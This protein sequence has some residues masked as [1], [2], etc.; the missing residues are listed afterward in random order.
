M[1]VS[2]KVSF[3]RKI[4]FCVFVYFGCCNYPFLPGAGHHSGSIEQ[5]LQQLDP[6][7]RLE[8]QNEL[9]GE[10]ALLTNDALS[11]KEKK[12]LE[13]Y[14]S[15]KQREFST[16]WYKAKRF[17]KNHKGKI[18]VGSVFALL[19][20]VSWLFRKKKT[21][22]QKTITSSPKPPLKPISSKKY[23]LSHGLGY[24]W[25]EKDNDEDIYV[26][27]TTIRCW[28][29]YQ[30][31]VNSVLKYRLNK[32]IDEKHTRGFY[33]FMSRNFASPSPFKYHSPCSFLWDEFI[34][35]AF[36]SDLLTSKNVSSVIKK[37]EESIYKIDKSLQKG[38]DYV[39]DGNA[40]FSNL[41]VILIGNTIFIAHKGSL[42][43]VLSDQGRAIS[44]CCKE[45]DGK[46]VEFKNSHISSFPLPD[47]NEF[48]VIGSYQLWESMKDQEVIDFVRKYVTD[49]NKAHLTNEEIA[50]KLTLH[51]R[52]KQKYKN[53]VDD[54]DVFIVFF[55][56]KIAE[57]DKNLKDSKNINNNDYMPQQD[58]LDFYSQESKTYQP[59]STFLLDRYPK[60]KLERIKKVL[61]AH[62]RKIKEKK[63]KVNE[64]EKVVESVEQQTSSSNEQEKEKDKQEHTRQK[65]VTD[66][67]QPPKSTFLLDRYPKEKLERIKKVLEAH[68]RKIKE[69]KEKVNEKEKVVESVEQQTS[70]SK[71]QKNRKQ[72]RLKMKVMM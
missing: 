48:I 59:R 71:E 35:N 24:S 41:S 18:T 50:Q 46:V 17:I 68:L 52:Q 70:S 21:V 26:H 65:K 62:L 44:L 56:R 20:F 25:Y 69:K 49:K 30:N 2:Q 55:N 27:G 28:Y 8:I 5:K 43:A 32:K 33:Q 67:N 7:L 60:E 4:V 54:I 16:R 6:E 53:D 15:A 22:P 11:E 63:E 29:G 13:D 36:K 61:E 58:N 19:A 45:D 1:L 34:N 3:V 14:I 64:K 51:V 72:K 37:I 9:R 31:Y 57:R 38:N 40:R 23:H 42:R 47:K 12:K 10:L 39:I 66:S